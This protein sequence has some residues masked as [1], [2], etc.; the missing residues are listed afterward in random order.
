MMF[1]M[2]ACYSG[3]ALQRSIGSGTTRFLKDMLKRYT[4]Q[5]LT[6]GKADETVSDADGPIPNHSVFT[7][8]LINGL[9]G[10]AATDQGI[11]SANGLMSYVYT[12]VA[13][14]PKSKQTPH[15]GCFEGDGDFI[16]NY[17]S[18]NSDNADHGKDMDKLIVIPAIEEDEFEQNLYNKIKKVKKL[19][20]DNS[21]T[22]E[23][24][25]YLVSEVQIFLSRST[26]DHF[27]T[28]HSFSSDELQNRLTKY[29]E[30]SLHMTVLLLC[31][32]HWGNEV[33]LKILQK[34]IGRAMDSLELRRGSSLWYRIHWYPM[35]T[36]MYYLGIAAVAGGRF[37][38]LLSM[39]STPVAI[40][41]STEMEETFLDS[42]RKA[43]L[44]LA[45]SNMWEKLPGLEKQ[46]TPLSEYLYELL[47]PIVDD[48]LFTGKSYDNL[49]DEFEVHLALAMSDAGT[50]LHNSDWGHIGRF[51]WKQFHYDKGPLLRIIENADRLDEKWEPLKAGL[52]GGDILRFLDV[53][54]GFQARIQ[55]LNWL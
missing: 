40:T 16:L 5:V 47:Q 53:A 23:L 32:A 50:Q 18:L 20:S 1:I 44:E 7:G 12:K 49:F 13:N 38:S 37:D 51:G 54:K 6:A 31:V 45:Q 8:H 3:L 26:E 36:L 55:K 4:R 21:S 52:F 25:D 11:I 2:D 27:S 24:H 42:V 43:M 15:Y 9:N 22:I 29:E 46:Y 48:V 30:I 41:D 10:E 28:H 34:M 39:F 33:H 14:D 19:L 35:I 17:T